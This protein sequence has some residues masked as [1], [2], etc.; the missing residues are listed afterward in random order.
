MTTRKK[1][2]T[3]ERIVENAARAIRRDGYDGVSV[4]DIMKEA[5]LTHGGFYAHFASRDALVLE[6]LEKASA[7]SLASLTK[8]GADLEHV[9]ERYLADA[10]V[11]HPEA[12]CA[13]AAL[14]SETRR[15]PAGV[16]ALTTRQVRSLTTLIEGSLPKGKDEDARRDEARVVLSALVGALVIARA[17]DSAETSAA[18]RRAVALFVKKKAR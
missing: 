2:E 13:L 7:E 3:H 15:Q 5:G 17:V 6:A 8:D 4:A 11:K 18:V 12:G 10:H 14:G 9:V 16:R 1:A